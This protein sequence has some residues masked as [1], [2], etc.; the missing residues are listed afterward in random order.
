MHAR[1]RALSIVCANT[2]MNA[3]AK[4]IY[5]PV[6]A[7]SSSA[8]ALAKR[9]ENMFRTLVHT[10]SIQPNAYAHTY[11]HRYSFRLMHG[12]GVSQTNSEPYI[13]IYI[14]AH[15]T[16]YPDTAKHPHTH[17]RRRNKAP[18]A[19]PLTHKHTRTPFTVCSLV[20]ELYC[21]NYN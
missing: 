12:N 15:H 6:G 10:H 16:K 8:L 1:L 11:T 20:R 5:G 14:Y 9:L 19:C 4:C 17:T 3:C 18:S 7:H 21:P 2:T 13:Y